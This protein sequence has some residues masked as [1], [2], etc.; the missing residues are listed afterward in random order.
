VFVK[1]FRGLNY[2]VP[3]SSKIDPSVKQLGANVRRARNARG[4]TQEKLA[5]LTN[6]HYRSIQKIEAGEMAIIVP[7]LKRLRDALKCDW[8]DLLGK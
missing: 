4:L 3:Q 2:A 8:S 1:A 7:T 5:E 6:L